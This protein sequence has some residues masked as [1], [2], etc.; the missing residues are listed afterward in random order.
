MSFFD[1]IDEDISLDNSVMDQETDMTEVNVIAKAVERLDAEFNP[2]S[3]TVDK[4]YEYFTSAEAHRR[5]GRLYADTATPGVSQSVIRRKELESLFDIKIP[6]KGM[7][8]FA[9]DYGDK[10]FYFHMDD[11]TY[12][13]QN[14]Q[15]NHFTYNNPQQEELR[16]FDMQNDASQIEYTEWKARLVGKPVLVW[17]YGPRLNESMAA[18]PYI[19]LG[20]HNG[21]VCPTDDK[22]FKLSLSN[23]LA[24]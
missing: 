24:L 5:I 17:G 11:G 16:F 4:I 15:F 14:V 1:D 8:N 13:Y 21:S 20:V 3:C 10:I 23:T 2:A 22:S 19:F 18:E 6:T 9:A 7:E 12:S